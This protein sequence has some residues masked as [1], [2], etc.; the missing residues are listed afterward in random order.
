MKE[1]AFTLDD[2][3]EVHSSKGILQ[4]SS[5]SRDAF[6]GTGSNVFSAACANGNILGFLLMNKQTAEEEEVE[7]AAVANTT[8]VKEGQGALDK[9]A[10]SSVEDLGPPWLPIVI[11]LV[12][13][14]VGLG[15][16]IFLVR[17]RRRQRAKEGDQCAMDDTS[18]APSECKSPSIDGRDKGDPMGTLLGLIYKN[19]KRVASKNTE[20]HDIEA[21]LESGGELLDD[22]KPSTTSDVSDLAMVEENDKEPLRQEEKHSGDDEDKIM[23]QHD[24]EEAVKADTGRIEEGDA[25][26][27]N[28]EA[29][30]TSL[31]LDGSDKKSRRRRWPNRKKSNS[32][33]A[34]EPSQSNQHDTLRRS[35]CDLDI[36][37]KRM[38]DSRELSN[39]I[40]GE[41]TDKKSR[42]RRRPN[43]KKS[44]SDFAN[45]PSQS[46]QHD[47]LRRSVCD[48]DIGTKRMKDSG[49]L[50]NLIFGETTSDREIDDK[51][52]SGHR[53]RYATIDNL[54]SGDKRY[55]RVKEIHQTEAYFA[56]ES[57]R[58]RGRKHDPLRQSVDDSNIGLRSR[59]IISTLNDAPKVTRRKGRKPNSLRQSVDD[60]NIG[61]RTAGAAAAA[62][63]EA[64]KEI[65]RK[66]RKPDP[67][68]DDSNIGL[69][70]AGAA[71]AA[72]TTLHEA[73]K[74]KRRKSRKPDPPQNGSNI[75]RPASGAATANTT[76][77]DAPR[78]QEGRRVESM[79][80]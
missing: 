7:A 47:T 31:N 45:E 68:Q 48:L 77:T 11:G 55:E 8:R 46:N 24:D 38:K 57:S 29:Q 80:H 34:N 66:S 71:A 19:K 30:G 65:R 22:D 40:L 63:N 39:L 27:S 25:D 1:P 23:D 56:A 42:R 58:R 50:S 79:I 78:R 62:L 41:T 5:P 33:F 2:Y 67:P 49:E 32:D 14:F 9:V 44:N 36:G 59:G 3:I 20:F 51:K 26:A 28:L 73:P 10:T 64:P 60:S 18:H 70:T 4:L 69:R 52:K 53:S 75:D 17:R 6:D 72:N 16:V 61:L 13:A 21:G 76:L 74:E 43:R 15:L 54:Q 12:C 37:T 35:V